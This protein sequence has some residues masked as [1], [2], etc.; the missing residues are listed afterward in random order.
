MFTRPLFETADVEE[1]HKHLNRIAELVDKDEIRTTLTETA[2]P[3]NAANLKKAHAMVESGR[4]KGKVVL[5][6]F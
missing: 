3:I 6:G 5:A 4:M 2:G 1:Q